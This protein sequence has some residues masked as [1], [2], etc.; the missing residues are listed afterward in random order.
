MGALAKPQG[1]PPAE[2]LG[3]SGGEQQQQLTRPP[4][5]LTR[6]RGPSLGLWGSP[7]GSPTLLPPAP[8]A[9]ED[10]S[11]AGTCPETGRGA[12]GAGET[13][14]AR[15][16][17]CIPCPGRSTGVPPRTSS[18]PLPLGDVRR[19]AGAAR[20]AG[21]ERRC[22]G[23]AHV[24]SDARGILGVVFQPPAP[25]CPRSLLHEDQSSGARPRQ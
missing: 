18:W 5:E 19:P 24:T 6:D 21:S 10:F 8:A 2:A 15:G 7:F 13:G 14:A 23:C 12:P 1:Q 11:P 25:T 17:C 22:K 9:R 4:P 16:R 3:A 20:R